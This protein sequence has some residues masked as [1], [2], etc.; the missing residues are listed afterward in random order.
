MTRYLTPQAI[1]SLEDKMDNIITHIGAVLPDVHRQA[2]FDI[3]DLLGVLQGVAGFASGVSQ[4]D[5]FA[6]IERTADVAQDLTMRLNCPTGSLEAVLGNLRRWLT[7]GSNYDP[8]EDSSDLDF[9]QVDIESVPEMM[10]VCL[11]E[12]VF[13]QTFD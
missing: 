13:N 4:K 5:A 12:I 7:F 9:D 6:V 1:Q 10:Q 8:L 3:E 11:S 2:Q